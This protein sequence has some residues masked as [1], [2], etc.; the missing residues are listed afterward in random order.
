MGKTLFI[1]AA[2]LFAVWIW[3]H[4]GE[5][6]ATVYKTV[7]ATEAGMKAAKREYE[8]NGLGS[9]SELK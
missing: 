6:K 2:T 3:E 7:D 5:T 9:A 1:I 8:S 4:P